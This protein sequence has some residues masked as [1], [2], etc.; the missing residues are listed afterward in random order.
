MFTW[1]EFLSFE[2]F[3]GALDHA[4]ILLECLG[5]GSGQ[6]AIDMLRGTMLPYSAFLPWCSR[7]AQSSLLAASNFANDGAALYTLSQ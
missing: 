4:G 7:L 1:Q 6:E 5:S 2:P 3:P